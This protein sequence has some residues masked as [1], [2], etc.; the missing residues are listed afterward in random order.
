VRKVPLR[1][2]AV[3]VLS[4]GALGGSLAIGGNGG[5]AATSGPI[6]LV[7]GYRHGAPS[8]VAAGLDQAY[9]LHRVATLGVLDAQVV[10]VGSTSL[11]TRLFELRHQPTVA[12]AQVDSLLTPQATPVTPNDPYFSGGMSGQEWGETR[13]QANYAWS[14]TTGSNSVTIAVID[15][16][17]SPTQ[18]DLQAQLVPGWNVLTK[19]PTRP[20]HT[21]T[22]PRW[23]V[24]RP[25]RRTMDRAS[26][27][28][29]GN[30]G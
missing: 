5:V 17:I 1:T 2:F 23:P 4:L 3:S 22:E 18:P 26:P 16:G 20:T 29:A 14:V 7:I 10:T 24:S 8:S 28:T 6:R 15:S 12:Y 21:G 9:G 19:V 11:A 27:V 25:R 30:A 13:D